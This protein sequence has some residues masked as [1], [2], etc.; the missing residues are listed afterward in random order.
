MSVCVCLCAAAYVI[1]PGVGAFGAAMARIHESPSLAAALRRRIAAG[2]PTLCVCLGH[3]L[4]GVSSDESIGAQGLGVVGVH[5]ERIVGPR[6]PQQ[7]WNY[8]RVIATAGATAGDDGG[9]GAAA[10]AAAPPLLADGYAY[11]SNSFC[12][13]A[14]PL[15]WSAATAVYGG[16]RFIAALQRGAVLSTQFHPELSGAYGHALLRRWLACGAA[17][18]AAGALRDGAAP[19]PATTAT[20]AAADVSDS[21]THRI[22]PCLDVKDGRVVKGVQFEGLRDAGDPAQLAALY[23]RQ[24]ADE[25]VMLDVSATPEGRSTASAL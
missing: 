5:C 23:E 2:R 25:L 12:M 19:T 1:L 22:I 14:A 6:V 24:G 20:P 9:G 21:L 8:V 11:F 10:A 3:Q 16:V 13:R 7:S 4:L 18:A 17:A 15:G